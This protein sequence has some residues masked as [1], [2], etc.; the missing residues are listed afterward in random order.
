M[1]CY[2]MLFYVYVMLFYVY[3][4][5]C[6]VMLCYV[7]LCYVMLCYVMLFY[8]ML[9]YVMLCFVLLCIYVCMLC[10][11]MYVCVRV[12]VRNAI[13]ICHSYTVGILYSTNTNGIFLCISLAALIK[14]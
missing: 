2:V 10:R 5:L 1:L 3:V 8:I 13:H 14:T 12:C 6:Y 11:Y 4:M 9:C 7:M